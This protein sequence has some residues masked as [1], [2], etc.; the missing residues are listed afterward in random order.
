[1]IWGLWGRIIFIVFA[2][3]FCLSA[4][5]RADVVFNESFETNGQG[6]RYTASTP[7]NKQGNYWDRGEN[8]DFDTLVAYTNPDGSF[9]WAAE[10]VD[11]TGPGGNGNPVQTL[12]FTGI[13]IAGF[14]DLVFSG[15]FASSGNSL[16]AGFPFAEADDG[17]KVLFRVDGGSWR[18][19]L[20]FAPVN[21]PF[22]NNLAHDTDCDGSGDG[23]VLTEDFTGASNPFTFNIPGGALLDLHI[24]VKAD[25]S[26]E[27]L[28]FDFFQVNGEPIPDNQAPTAAG[29]N[30]PDVGEPEIGN[31]S[32]D[33]TITYSDNSAV[34]VST[35]DIN[36]VKVT[37]PSGTLTV[38]GAVEPTGIDGAPRTATYTVT[39][40]GGSWNA[41]DNG[42]Y[43]I[44][45]RGNEVGDDGSP[46]LFVASD[47]TLTTFNVNATN[48][49]PVVSGVLA[50]DVIF[51]DFGETS[52]A[53][54][55]EYSDVAGIDISSIDAS[56]VTVTGP[57]G[58]LVVTGVSVDIGTNGSPRNATYA[59]TP[60]GGSWDI[61]DAGTYTIGV[62]ASEVLDVLGKAV[63]ANPALTTFDVLGGKLLNESFETN[64]QGVRYTA[65]PPFNAGEYGYWDRGRNGDFDTLTPYISG[66][67]A[68][69]WAAENVDA[70]GPGGN[71]N[72]VQTLEFTG[73]NIAGHAKLKFNGLFAATQQLLGSGF[74]Y[75]AGHGEHI[76]VLYQVN[77]G[78]FQNGLW[79]TANANSH[80][81]LDAN[82]DGAGDG[83]ELVDSFLPYSFNI[84]DGGILDLRIEVKADSASEEVAFDS[85]MVTGNLLPPNVAP[86]VASTSAPDVCEPEI[87]NTSYNF[88]VT[89]TDDSAVDVSTIDIDDV[90]VTGPIG[91]LK[92][93][94]AVEPTGIDGA[95]RTATYT[96][97]PPG[98]WWNAADNGTYTIDM[99]GNEVGD[100][101]SPQLFVA[102]DPILATFNVNATNMPPVVSGVLAEDVIFLNFCEMSYAF[103]IEYS[104]VAGIDISSIDTNDVT[105]TGPS[106]P[107]VVTGASVDNTTNGSPRTITYRVTPPGGSWDIADAG[108]YTIGVTGSE[109][110]D[111]LG[112]AVASNPALISFDVLPGTLLNESFETDGQ[113][114]RY[115]A[116]PPFNVGV[117]GHWD[118]GTNADFN[119]LIPYLSGEGTFFWA[120]EDTDEAP[121]NGNPVQILEFTGINIAGHTN[122]AF[123]GLF[124][125]TQQFLGNGFPYNSGQGEHVKVLYQVN[126]GGFQNGV[127]FT[128]NA[129]S[130]LALDTNFDGAG[131]GD[132]LVDSFLPYSFS[133]PDGDTL[134]LRIEVKADSAS[135]EVAFDSL[136]VIGDYVG[137]FQDFDGGN[138]VR[139]T[140]NGAAV[141]DGGSALLTKNAGGQ[142]G[143][144]IFGPLSS[145][146][147]GS[148]EISFDF[149]IGPSSLGGADGL[150]F[151]LMDSSIYNKFAVFG[152]DGPGADSLAVSFDTHPNAGEPSGNF[153]EILFNGKSVA[154]ADPTF[155]LDTTQWHHADISFSSNRLTLTLTPYRGFPITVFGA[156]PVPGFTPFVSLYGF[157]GR[158]GGASS[159]HR[160]D[161]VLFVNTSG[162]NDCDGDLV[163]DAWDNCPDDWN[164]SQTDTDGDGVGDDCDILAGCND[165]ANLYLDNIINL[166]D[167]ADYAIDY[168]CTSG[169]TADIDGDGDTDIVDMSIIAANWL[170]SVD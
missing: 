150:S 123:N 145:A 80:L 58:P 167:F 155:N 119:T 97:T 98:G 59:V 25:E 41:A 86:S 108:R 138:G 27:E 21:A 43:T 102:A 160:V 14:T 4:T 162:G 121:G 79:F 105:V 37:G 93:T 53:F 164:P 13:N 57:G 154:M 24:E 11:A 135:E 75:N 143:S 62:T 44:G 124:A 115:M 1:M 54:T 18:K 65:S 157:G 117:D 129:N 76:K 96:V 163:P 52:Y 91:A 68:F 23:A 101:G 170:C 61:T 8:S 42:T 166:L 67:G 31:T 66:D 34:D 137:G 51:P 92:V 6:S 33:F 36:D 63:A 88:T 71:G 95:P 90:K 148:F 133:I 46:Q 15:L 87:G 26:S 116:S 69:F 7:F 146:P 139:F 39:P 35:I 127:W 49:P 84:P 38:T 100:N 17:I 122:L 50:E 47:P 131:D 161:N 152:E 147:V 136:M 112:A 10:D 106:G 64:G 103:T 94:G 114:V 55:I 128:A 109:V 126:G 149:R 99:R 56:D 132:E 156:V 118:R 134:D 130:H 60:P 78:G 85:L 113:G 74:P 2:G 142:I 22:L 169:C 165:M 140:T 28:A 40:P 104:D 12:D 159:E 144:V 120:A 3:C 48:M 32:Y 111:V 9:F 73:I 16:G 141:V 107:L 29:F 82:F 110:L 89:Y 151:A 30:A 81:A 45:I 20:C 153:V 70:T 19:G 77:G 168:D 72:P 158:T 5:V 83:T 125:A